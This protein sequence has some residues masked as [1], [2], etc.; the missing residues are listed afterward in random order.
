[1]DKNRLNLDQRT[2]YYLRKFSIVDLNYL[3]S[4]K[5]NAD[6]KKRLKLTLNE[7]YDNQ[8]GIYVKARSF[9]DKMMKVEN[10]LLRKD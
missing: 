3:N 10:D 9:I 7:I 1:M 5:V 8:V 6:T 2:M 4:I